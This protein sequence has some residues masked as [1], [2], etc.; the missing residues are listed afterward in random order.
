[1]TSIQCACTVFKAT[2]GTSPVPSRLA[3][4]Q[5]G[6]EEKISLGVVKSSGAKTQKAFSEPIGTKTPLLNEREYLVLENP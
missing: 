4:G 5:E 2:A 6:P 1:M 3:Q